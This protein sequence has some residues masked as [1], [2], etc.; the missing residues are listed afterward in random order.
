MAIALITGASSG[1]GYELSRVFAENHYDLVLIARSRDRL[2]NWQE[3]WKKNMAFIARCW[4]LIWQD[5]KR[6]TRL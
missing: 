2:I 3:S 5:H 6:R 4:L 1:I